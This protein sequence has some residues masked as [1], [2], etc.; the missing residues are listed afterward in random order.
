VRQVGKGEAVMGMTDS[1]D[2]FGG[3][4]EGLPI[5]SVVLQED[6]LQI[7]NSVGILKNAPHPQ[8]AQ[9]LFDYLK[10]E[11]VLAQLRKAGALEPE[12]VKTV[13]GKP[14]DWNAILQS[15]PVA[16]DALKKIFLR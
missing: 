16:L 4:H 5:G 3:L 9:K 7:G 13:S 12:D 15:Q 1:D 6:G 2:V 8:A 11:E 10:S 14:V